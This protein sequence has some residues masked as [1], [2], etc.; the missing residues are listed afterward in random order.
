MGTRLCIEKVD[1]TLLKEKLM[2]DYANYDTVKKLWT[3]HN[4]VIRTNDTL[5][6][7][8]VKIPEMVM[9]YPF[10]PLDLNKGDAIKE[11]LTTP[12]LNE[13]IKAEQLRGQENLNNYVIERVRRTATPFAGFILVIIGACIASRKIRGG[14]GLHIALGIVLSAIFV[15]FLQLTTTF[16][17]KSS[18]DPTV[19]VWIPNFI[20]GALAFVLYRW[21]I[22]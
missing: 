7:R 22:R 1:G 19:A 14:S 20:F 15:M 4:V 17:T 6:E 9:S 8:L 5:K 21:Q 16:A 3:L 10:S 2:A 13:Y 11:A 12:Q 18:L